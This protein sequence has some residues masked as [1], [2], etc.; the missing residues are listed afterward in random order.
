MTRREKILATVVV[1][2]IAAALG[3]GVWMQRREHYVENVLRDFANLSHQAESLDPEGLPA[4]RL[5]ETQPQIQQL[6]LR[7]EYGEAREE[8]DALQETTHTEQFSLLQLD[9][10]LT[11]N[12]VLPPDS[13]ERTRAQKLLVALVE[14]ENT[15]YD[16]ETVRAEL[17][18]T[19]GHALRGERVRALKSLERAEKELG[20]AQKIPGFERLAEVPLP[21]DGPLPPGLPGLEAAGGP[22][23]MAAGP[24]PGGMMSP[25]GAQALQSLPPRLRNRLQALQMSH[26]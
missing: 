21:P 16:T 1:L 8:L 3:M 19:G 4:R 2:L 6:I 24:L 5:K 23:G 7:R 12:Q 14:K 22:R 11:V 17:A 25:E 15:G 9:R 10:S 20:K 26:F 18:R 13:P